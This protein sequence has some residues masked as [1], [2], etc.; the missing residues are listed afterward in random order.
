MKTCCLITVSALSFRICV[1]NSLILFE[2]SLWA[3]WLT[4]YIENQITVK[5]TELNNPLRLEV[6][7]HITEAGYQ[8]LSMK[9]SHCFCY[10]SFVKLKGL[11]SIHDW[12]IRV[13]KQG[14]RRSESTA[15]SPSYYCAAWLG[16]IC[17][18][19]VY[20]SLSLFS[21]ISWPAWRSSRI[22]ISVHYC[23]SYIPLKI[24]YSSALKIL[25]C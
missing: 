18:L 12:C 6:Q 19:F 2:T 25:V 10:F 23:R 24:I 8:S 14:W 13:P 11:S 9:V 3:S 20:L 16:C 15:G 1:W 22:F 5:R 7:L 4:R 21:F 17:G